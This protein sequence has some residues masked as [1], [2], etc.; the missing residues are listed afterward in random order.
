LLRSVFLAKALSTCSVV[1]IDVR[2]MPSR[3]ISRSVACMSSM[4]W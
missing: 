2:S 3:S 1:R 4:A